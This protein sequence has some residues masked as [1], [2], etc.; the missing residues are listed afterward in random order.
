MPGFRNVDAARVRRA[1][2]WG[3]GA[4]AALVM[5]GGCV[6]AAP[7]SGGPSGAPAVGANPVPSPSPAVSAA[8]TPAAAANTAAAAPA[9]PPAVIDVTPPQVQVG[10]VTLKMT[11]EP[12]RHMLAQ[13]AAMTTDPDAAH[14]P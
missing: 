4:V 6:A 2:V 10:D 9:L 11:V 7:G 3:S 1:A 12:A 5:A 14:Q 13:T 8:A